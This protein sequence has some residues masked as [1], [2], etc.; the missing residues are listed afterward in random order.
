MT[1]RG[2]GERQET[3]RAR[4]ADLRRDTEGLAE[5]GVFDY[6][7]TRLDQ[8]TSAAA[9]R[10]RA[11]E[12]DAAVA[13]DQ[14]SAVRILAALVEALDDTAPQD[15]EFRESESGNEGGGSGG[16]AGEQPLI[17]PLS[18]LR[19][20]R[21]MQQEAADRTREA[22]ESPDPAA[23]EELTGL[24]GDL[25]EQLSERGLELIEKMEQQPPQEPNP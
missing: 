2:A 13:R 14:D 4:L 9:K 15:D 12:A 24:I 10:L 25:Q 5:A 8:T 21:A 7:H 22:N 11:G 18:E 17:P 6:A 23:A 20:L 16:E 1:L 3:L 19:L